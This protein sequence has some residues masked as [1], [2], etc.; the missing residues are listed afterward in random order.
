MLNSL[1]TTLSTP[2]MRLSGILVLE[3]LVSLVGFFSALYLNGA[4]ERQKK[5]QADAILRKQ[6]YEEQRSNYVSLIHSIQAL[7]ALTDTLNKHLDDD[8]PLLSFNPFQVQSDWEF[9][10]KDSTYFIKITCFRFN[11][12]VVLTKF[13]QDPGLTQLFSEFYWIAK[14]IDQINDHRAMIELFFV[15]HGTSKSPAHKRQLKAYLGDYYVLMTQL[16]GGLVPDSGYSD[17]TFDFGENFTEEMAEVA[18]NCKCMSA[19]PSLKKRTR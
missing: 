19:V 6:L 18:R 1:K 8:A 3:L 15:E 7:G 5:E 14:K 4:D 12:H 11:N 2:L 9:W 13:T 10:E 16:L 17:I